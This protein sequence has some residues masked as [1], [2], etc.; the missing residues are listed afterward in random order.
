MHSQPIQTEPDQT[1]STG[2]KGSGEDARLNNVLS[3]DIREVEKAL[4]LLSAF[5]NANEPQES[6]RLAS[7]LTA[8]LSHLTQDDSDLL[9]EETSSQASGIS[10]HRVK[11]NAPKIP[12]PHG[13]KQTVVEKLRSHLNELM[14]TDTSF[15][16]YMKGGAHALQPLPSLYEKVG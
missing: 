14:Q 4:T 3:E 12:N 6:H 15:N 9:E 7:D 11:R 8:V 1:E 13:L 5:E 16:F 10:E 2:A